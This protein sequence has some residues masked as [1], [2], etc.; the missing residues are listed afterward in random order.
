[1][2]LET[3]ISKHTYLRP[4]AD[5][6]A[7]LSAAVSKVPMS[8]ART[9]N[10]DS[11]ADDYKN[12]VPLLWSASLSIDRVEVEKI[13]AAVLKKSSDLPL[14]ETTNHEILDLCHSGS[15]MLQQ[16]VAWLVA[17]DDCTIPHPGLFRHIGWTVLAQYF[18]PM[19]CAFESWRDE[20]SW[21][22][23][24]CPVCGSGPSMS[25][26]VGTD[27]GRRRL[28][29][30][31]CCGTRWRFRRIGCPFCENGH[32]HRL[33]VLAIEG[34]KHLRIDYCASCLGYLKTYDGEGAESVM[35]AD[36]TSIHL[37]LLAKDRELKRL[38]TSLYQI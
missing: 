11:Y 23:R 1:M 27:P 20:E 4:L 28:L 24:Y 37:D 7:Q 6:H 12:G 22:R 38:A 9:P 36:W 31:G 18:F 35:L 33:S 19:V 8:Y 25:Q 30:C 14:G 34:E 2:T 10:W 3:W 16:A 17:N 5:F 21:F 29:I 32:D 15:S 13:I 26:L